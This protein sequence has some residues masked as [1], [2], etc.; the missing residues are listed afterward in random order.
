MR[1]LY[2]YNDYFK[3]L[4]WIELK[5]DS[6][7][8]DQLHLSDQMH[9]WKISMLKLSLKNH[10]NHSMINRRDFQNQKK[11]RIFYH[12]TSWPTSWMKVD[13]Q[14]LRPTTILFIVNLDETLGPG[15][16][17]V[18]ENVGRRVTPWDKK[19]TSA[20]FLKGNHRKA[21]NNEHCKVAY[22]HRL[23]CITVN[24]LGMT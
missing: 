13:G 5:K 12:L 3:V 20:T 21:G 22:L 11:V 23:H 6:E 14:S 18:E 1:N 16:Y 15:Y 24:N 2:P 10:T 17:T 4:L 8:I 9:I 19:P 7:K